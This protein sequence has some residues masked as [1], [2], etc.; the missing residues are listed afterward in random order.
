MFGRCNRVEEGE[1]KGVMGGQ[2]GKGGRTR[3]GRTYLIEHSR[4]GRAR[5][6]GYEILGHDIQLVVGLCDVLGDLCLP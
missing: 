6:L 5:H 2:Y 3:K 4:N 1:S